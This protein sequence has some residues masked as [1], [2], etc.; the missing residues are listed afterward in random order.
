VRREAAAEQG[1]DALAQ[2]DSTLAGAVEL[3]DAAKGCAVRPILG[4][5]LR[6]GS[7]G[8]RPGR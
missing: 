3:M 2:T 7:Q 1:Y 4:A 5:R 8:A 6:Q